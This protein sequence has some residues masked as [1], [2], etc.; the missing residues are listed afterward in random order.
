[1]HILI[2]AE[3]LVPL[4]DVISGADGSQFLNNQLVA[5]IYSDELLQANEAVHRERA[6]RLL[7]LILLGMMPRWHQVDA[8]HLLQKDSIVRIDLHGANCF[9]H[10]DMRWRQ[11]DCPWR[12]ISRGGRH[13]SYIELIDSMYSG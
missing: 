2:L 8:H 11:V 10:V 3:V 4:L 1:M 7:W 12:C 9:L 13:S 5:L 6:R